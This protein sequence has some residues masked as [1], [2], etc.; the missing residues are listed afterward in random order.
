MFVTYVVAC[1]LFV[2]LALR[3]KVLR[4]LETNQRTE[5]G[6]R[7]NLQTV[8]FYYYYGDQIKEDDM[9][10]ILSSYH[11]RVHEVLPLDRILS[12]LNPLHSHAVF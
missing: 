8:L 6:E 12:P 2:N 3:R 7:R 1:S 5:T 9:D 10:G 4:I 11:Y